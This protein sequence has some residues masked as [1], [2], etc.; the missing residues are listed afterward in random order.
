MLSNPLVSDRLR[1]RFALLVA[2]LRGESTISAL[3]DARVRMTKAMQEDTFPQVVIEKV[4]SDFHNSLDETGDLQTDSFDLLCRGTTQKSAVD[5]ADAVRDFIKDYTG[6]TGVTGQTIGAVLLLGESD[7]YEEPYDDS[8]VGV[9]VVT[10]NID[11]QW[12]P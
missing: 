2:L 6:A 4:G 11:V 8:D 7:D 9:Y 1:R 3:V 5:V 10:L 12:N